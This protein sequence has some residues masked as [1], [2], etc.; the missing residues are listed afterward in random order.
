[1]VNNLPSPDEILGKENG[2]LPSPKDV[3]GEEPL[4]KKA[5]SPFIAAPSGISVKKSESETPSTSNPDLPKINIAED[6]KPQSGET[7]AQ[8]SQQGKGLKTVEQ[9]KKEGGKPSFENYVASSLSTLGGYV[10]EHLG[11]IAEGTEQAGKAL[12]KAAIESVLPSKKPITEQIKAQANNGLDL[13]LG[14]AKTAFG[15]ASFTPAGAALNVA[16]ETIIPDK[17]NE[18]LFSPAH[19]IAEQFGYIPKEHEGELKEKAL[20]VG[21]LVGS[22][23]AIKGVEH[24]GEMAGGIAKEQVNT[25][26]DKIQNK[27]RLTPDES[28]VVSDVVNNTTPE[29]LHN[30]VI[31]NKDKLK[32][33]FARKNKVVDIVEKAKEGA[34]IK[35]DIAK[36][37]DIKKE[38]FH[39]TVDLAKEADQITES[40]AEE[41][42]STFDNVE[43]AKESIPDEHKDNPKIIELVAKKN[44]LLEKKKTLDSAFHP[45]IDEQI[46]G[47]DN[48]NGSHK[49]GIDDKIV[50]EIK[51]QKDEQAKESTEAEALRLLEEERDKFIDDKIAALKGDNTIMPETARMIYGEMFDKQQIENKQLKTEPNA[52]QKRSTEKIPVQPTPRN[53]G[54]MEQ[55]IS[56]P[57]EPAGTRSQ[58]E[59]PQKE[60]KQNAEHKKEEEIKIKE[61]NRGKTPKSKRKTKNQNIINAR[62]LEPSNAHEQVMQ[63]FIDGGK[64][65]RKSIEELYKGEK[66]RNVRVGLLNNKIGLTVDELAH[67]LWENRQQGD[68]RFETSDYKNAIEEVL[69][70]HLSDVQ[71]A[72]KMLETHKEKIQEGQPIEDEDYYNS[73]SDKEKEQMFKDNE[74]PPEEEF[75][76]VENSILTPLVKGWKELIDA[77]RKAFYPESKMRKAIG[78]DLSAE[79]MKRLLSPDVTIEGF[80]ET[81]IKEAD[82]TIGT[83][84]DYFK[85]TY[86][87][88]D[89]KDANRAYGDPITEE[90]KKIKELA[91]ERLEKTE[92]GKE[93]LYFNEKVRKPISDEVFGMAQKLGFM[94]ITH[95]KDYFYGVFNGEE[96]TKNI[97]FEKLKEEQLSK[98]KHYK[99]TERFT[100]EKTIP[101]V[102][103]AEGYG[104]GGLKVSN[105]V[106][107]IM[108]EVYAI[109]KRASMKS[110]FNDVFENNRKFAVKTSQAD[111]LTQSEW[112]PIEDPLFDGYIFH[113]DFARV[114]NNFIEVNAFSKSKPAK[115]L[116]G[117]VMASQ[118]IKFYGSAFHL[119]N[120]LKASI[121]SGG[122]KGAKNFFKSINQEID[123]KDPYYMKWVEHGGGIHYAKETETI[124]KFQ[125][126]YDNVM[127]TALFDNPI[128]EKI[129]IPVKFI[130]GKYN[131]LSPAFAKAMFNE[132][133]P[134]MKFEKFKS[135]AIKLEQNIGRPLKA[136]ELITLTKRSQEFFGEMNEKLYGRS[137]TVT[138]LMRLIFMAPG[139]GEG[140]FLHQYRGVKE[141][142]DVGKAITKGEGKKQLKEVGVNNAAFIINSM[143]TTAA[144]ATI[145]T[146]IMTG[147]APKQPKDAN[148]VRDLFKINTGNKD[149]NGNDIYI[150]MMTYDKDAWMI[151][152]N[153]LS[154]KGSKG[155]EDMINRLT[156]MES[157]P[158]KIETDIQMILS[159]GTVVD[160]KNEP[161]YNP[162]DDLHTKL[163]KFIDYESNRAEPISWS[164]F[165]QSMQKG[166]NVS[167]SFVQAV[168]G[169]R[170]AKS[171]SAKETK[172]ALETNYNLRSSKTVKVGDLNKLYAEN[173]KEAI[174]EA[175]KFNKQQEDKLRDLYI[176]EYINKNQEEPTKSWI[177]NRLSE[178]NPSDY[179]ITKLSVKEKGQA[180]DLLK[181][182]TDEGGRPLQI[183]VEEPEE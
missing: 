109:A 180:A 101:T 30:A 16:A 155:G 116:R 84:I 37:F 143:L 74:L 77:A 145:G 70:D 2:G 179:Y 56:E 76:I 34:D 43:K 72:E 93:L 12:T 135:D 92:H 130:L 144:M 178:D 59:S 168:G 122:I 152:G 38:D 169:F 23:F 89:M 24:I 156:G 46:K 132:W 98:E 14:S 81:Y 13:L 97:V 44:E 124:K 164:T 80:R 133:I 104:L 123:K 157:S 119:Y 170:S 138:S 75:K 140:N 68:N 162:S 86:S 31:D 21:D 111:P 1:M 126:Y 3:L 128:A 114:V 60:S 29:E 150:D 4:K 137:G 95:F 85:K 110:V 103:D 45:E 174:K 153:L 36:L 166:G 42:K 55:G 18:W 158:F 69:Q 107:N 147:K 79:T 94:D 118:A 26:K 35:K 176:Q 9:I 159:G 27:E 32:P 175:E 154:G 50:K 15:A 91:V 71:M 53:S 73:L 136:K 172:K 64:L 22:L 117:L 112:K 125:G 63:Y 146:M 25:I 83:L 105:P 99:T 49:P 58:Q 177:K 120:E 127:K 148:D 47:K 28:K 51:K 88:E 129:G 82:T 141:L 52:I 161:L 62:K 183:E 160:Y 19:K 67:N 33:L 149:G 115:I 5:L 131:P 87:E 108:S 57:E 10:G 8:P 48:E 40:K 90:G 17:V 100:K 54:T 181:G 66:E 163:W 167:S 96:G 165:N 106:E 173:P 61:E 20:Q 139:Y 78:E 182:K 41:L 102:A 65:K 6:I 134:K 11:Q 7:T 151:F 113:P 121:A 39:Q 142:K 171:E